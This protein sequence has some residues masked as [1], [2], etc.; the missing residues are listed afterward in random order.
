VCVCV[1]VCVC[2]CISLFLSL[3]LSL[4]LSLSDKCVAFHSFRQVC[5]LSILSVCLSVCDVSVTQT[6]ANGHAAGKVPMAVFFT[7][8]S[9]PTPPLVKALSTKVHFL[10]SLLSLL[11]SVSVSLC[12]SV[13]LFLSLSLSVS[14]FLSLFLFLC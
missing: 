7:D 5:C 3:R 1:C 13:S 11:P 4:C 12:L 9:G 14:L 8:K 10:P 2:L 6:H